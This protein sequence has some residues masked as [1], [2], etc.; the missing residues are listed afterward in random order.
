MNALFLT[1]NAM[2][3]MARTRPWE[4]LLIIVAILLANA[5]LVTVLLINEGASQGALTQQSGTLLNG[6]IITAAQQQPLAAQTTEPLEAKQLRV[7]HT[8]ALHLNTSHYSKLRKAGFTD[9]IAFSQR[10]VTLQCKEKID[11]GKTLNLIGLDTQPLLGSRFKQLNIQPSRST[12]TS[13]PSPSGQFI[14]DAL[15]NPIT[16]A[17]LN[18]NQPLYTTGEKTWPSDIRVSVDSKMPEDTLVVSIADFYTDNISPFNTPLAGLIS[19]TELTPA[20]REQLE[21]LLPFII[22]I[23]STYNNDTGTLPESFTLNLWAMSML[24]GVVALFIVLNALNLMYKA[25]LF[26]VLRFRQ[27]GVSSRLLGV[28]LLVELLFYCTLGVP[29]GIYVG[30]EAASALSPVIKGTFS[31][32]F[33]AAFVTPDIDVIFIFSLAFFITFVALCL[34]AIVP[35]RQLSKS[36]L[37]HRQQ[38]RSAPSIRFVCCT[39]I[40]MLVVLY[41]VSIFINSTLSALLFVAALLLGSCVL[42]LLW[43]PVLAFYLARYAPKRFPVLHFSIANTHHLSSRTRLAVC[44]FFIALT[45]NIG[46]NTMTDSFRDATERWLSQ[47][48]YA[49]FYLYTKQA[50]STFKAPAGMLLTPL[51][52]FETVMANADVTLSSYPVHNAGQQALVLD[53]AV[54][55]AWSQFV[56]ANGVFINQQFAYK[57]AIKLG[58]SISID[59]QTYNQLYGGMLDSTSDSGIL[60]KEIQLNVLGIYPD[61]GNL[62]NQ[63][64]IPLPLFREKHKDALFSG[65]IALAPVEGQVS[66]ERI[67]ALLYNESQKQAA[68]TDDQLFSREALL[69]LSMKTFDKTFVLTDGLNIVT[70]LVAGLAFAISLSILALANNSQLSVLRAFG[71]SQLR[72]KLSLLSQYMVICLLTAALALPFGIYLASVFINYVNRFAFNWTY[73]LLINVS[74]MAFTVLFSLAFILSVILLPLGKLKPKVDLRQ[75][76]QL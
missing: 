27:L 59:R 65:V 24:M 50:L 64:L 37:T 46:M 61:Y 39:S 52:Q 69:A 12:A 71:V 55:S 15:I 76:S 41:G 38:Q 11:N 57:H 56:E 23:K 47:R 36:L 44:A 25:R 8:N 13:K 21:N 19:I 29:I 68:D 3:A 54:P 63:V 35:V 60:S 34:F 58:D 31:S 9:I 26:N 75:E 70:L 53:S 20:M 73:P 42:V 49:P 48:L 43:L 16:V 17:E 14:I 74:T 28:A 18:C 72:V 10:E 6:T 5:G 40:V 7:S 51:L 1:F 62:E 30:F 22:N 67:K 32:L 45:A 4:P 66:A 33:D 2:L